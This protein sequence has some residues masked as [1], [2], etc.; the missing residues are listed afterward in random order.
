VREALPAGVA[1]T[2]IGPTTISTTIRDS[3]PF[4]TTINLPDRLSG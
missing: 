2:R 3:T 1:R 4:L